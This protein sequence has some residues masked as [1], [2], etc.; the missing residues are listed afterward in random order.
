MPSTSSILNGAL[1]AQS[2]AGLPP[3]SDFNCHAV[4]FDKGSLPAGNYQLDLVVY[5]WESGQ[6]LHADN[7]R[8]RTSGEQIDLG[9]FSV[10]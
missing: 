1:I 3:N 8:D 4:E 9:S 2:D 7:A 6:R 5:A 10:Q